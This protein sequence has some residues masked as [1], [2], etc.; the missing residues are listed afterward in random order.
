M[1][2]VEQRAPRLLVATWYGDTLRFVLRADGDGCVLAFT[3][4]L[5]DEDATARTAAGW[6][7]C[8]ARVDAL[9]DGEPLG[10]AEAL[11]AWPAAHE[12]YVAQFGVDPEPGRSAYAAHPLTAGEPQ[13]EPAPEATSR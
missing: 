8:F 7:R 6:E 4:A 10:E 3:H 5:G 13:S 9:L 12:R 11:E 2:P 1:R